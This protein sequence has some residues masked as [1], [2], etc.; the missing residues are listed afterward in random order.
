MG[1]VLNLQARKW[2]Y[3]VVMLVIA[4]VQVEAKM[5]GS[6][7]LNSDGTPKKTLVNLL[8]KLKVEHNGTLKGIVAATQKAW[9]RKPGQERWD[10]K[11]E[12]DIGDKDSVLK[13]LS[14]CGCIDEVYPEEKQYD[15]VLV[16]GALAS[17]IRYRLDYVVN[18]WKKGT[19]FKEVVFLGSERPRNVDR[20]TA[21][22]LYRGSYKKGIV[23]PETECE[24]MKLL[25]SQ[26]DVSREFVE[27]V[28]VT[29]INAPMRKNP[30]GKVMQPTASDA[31][32]VWLKDCAK[33]G[34]CL[35]VS[36]NPYLGYTNSVV[37]TFLPSSF[38][39]ETVGPAANKMSNVAVHLDN[40]TRW[41][42][43]EQVRRSKKQ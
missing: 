5:D 33:P 9:L 14:E 36:N 29:F 18:F 17:G 34:T 42:Y 35:V 21:E 43:Q 28:H 20:E 15:Y 37:K 40:L 8:S 26:A 38:T 24:I 22:I 11:K 23:F 3:S 19:R 6:L 25:F 7:I 32:K 30:N 13:L 2:Y 27:N 4:S 10:L 39:V 12:V 41:L 31:L 16:M 1:K